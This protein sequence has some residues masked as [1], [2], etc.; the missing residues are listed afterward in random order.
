MNYI[1]LKLTRT[2][3]QW[4][5]ICNHWKKMYFSLENIS[6]VTSFQCFRKYHFLLLMFRA[7][8]NQQIHRNPD[9][10]IS[11][12]KLEKRL[13]NLSPKEL[14]QNTWPMR[15]VHFRPKINQ[16]RRRKYF[17]KLNRILNRE[18]PAALQVPT[19][20]TSKKVNTRLSNGKLVRSEM[21]NT[22]AQ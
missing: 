15:Q 1:M 12:K 22:P 11:E 13:S 4:S 20:H 17:W 5:N 7:C 6:K 18:T 2:Y 16:L 19:R 10:R 9:V 21:S 3:F 14:V 8:M